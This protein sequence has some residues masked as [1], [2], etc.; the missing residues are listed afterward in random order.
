MYV[1]APW[2]DR[3][4]NGIAASVALTVASMSVTIESDQ[5]L[6]RALTFGTKMSKAPSDS[7]QAPNCAL[8][9]TSTA[10]ASIEPRHCPI[11]RSEESIRSGSRAQK[12][13]SQPSCA[14]TRTIAAPIPAEP[15]VTTAFKPVSCKSTSHLRSEV[16]DPRWQRA[17]RRAIL[18]AP[19]DSLPVHVQIKAVVRL[20]QPHRHRRR[21]R[22]I[23]R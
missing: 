14:K 1:M 9:E 12:A 2:E 19:R 20:H 3:R 11:A 10:L 17:V 15:P 7:S 13:T 21:D 16:P 8:S 5:L 22:A 6:E 18:R 4:R 23:S